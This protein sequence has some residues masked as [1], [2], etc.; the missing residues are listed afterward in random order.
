MLFL[1]KA[2]KSDLK[3]FYIELWLTIH[4]EGFPL[5]SAGALAED[6]MCCGM[7]T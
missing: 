1:V 2:C 3:V 5:S 4:S 7:F 6:A